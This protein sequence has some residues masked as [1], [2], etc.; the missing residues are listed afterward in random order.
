MNDKVL[1]ITRLSTQNA[2][3]EALSIE[4]INLVKSIMPTAE[5]RA[6]DR[7]PTYFSQF[8]IKKLGS[9][10]TSVLNNFEALVRKLSGEFKGVSNELADIASEAQVKLDKTAKELPNWFRQIKRKI[11]FR[12]RLASFGLT[13]KEAAAKAVNSCVWA[14]LVIW[15]P[16]GE[17]H[18]PGKFSQTMSD[19]V[20]RLLLLIRIAQ[21]NNV[22]TMIINHSLEIGDPLLRVLLKQVYESSEQITVRDYRSLQEALGLGLDPSRVHEIP[23]MVYLAAEVSDSDGRVTGGFEK[24]TICFAI[25]GRKAFGM[26]HEWDKL[27]S[28]VKKLG[29]PLGFLSNAMHHDI[30]F[31]HELAK[32]HGIQVAP[33]QPTYREIKDYYQNIDI[34]VGSRLHSNVL[35]LC[36]GVPVVSLEASVFKMTGVFEQMDYPIPT[37]QMNGEGWHVEVVK[38]IKEALNE[39]DRLSDYSRQVTREQARRIRQSYTQLLA[40]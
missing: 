18:H 11:G 4:L 2:G 10:E 7:Y 19:E 1:L 37:S 26:E 9:T 20:F 14:D 35:A 23:D 40:G 33:G 21:I 32:K 12:K 29:R 34:L 15:N 31:V 24:G 5:I 17:I 6:L 36:A 30:P 16:A 38:K 39:R 8:N 27:F 22:R 13:G 28:E 25:N 3:N